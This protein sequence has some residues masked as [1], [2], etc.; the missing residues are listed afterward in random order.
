M[1]TAGH[2]PCVV[3]CVSEQSGHVDGTGHPC[4]HIKGVGVVQWHLG[5]PSGALKIPQVKVTLL[6][7]SPAF[8]VVTLPFDKAAG[9]FL[10]S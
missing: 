8:A 5:L 4:F 2:R 6:S 9:S 1:S 7:P 10:F 3:E